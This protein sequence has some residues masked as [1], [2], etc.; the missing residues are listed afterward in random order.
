MAKN[1]KYL[2]LSDFA[3]MFRYLGAAVPNYR[4]RKLIKEGRIY[5]EFNPLLDGKWVVPVNEVKKI[6]MLD[7]FSKSKRFDE[8]NENAKTMDVMRKERIAYIEEQIERIKNKEK[9]LKKKLKTLKK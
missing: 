4:I 2:Y 5:A 1:K 8:I 7:N 9:S 6:E 3:K